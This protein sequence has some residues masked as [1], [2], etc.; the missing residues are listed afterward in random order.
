MTQASQP[1][2]NPDAATAAKMEPEMEITRLGRFLE[3][4]VQRSRLL[5]RIM[6]GIMAALVIANLIYPAGYDR[7][8]WET[9]GGAGAM[10]GL[11]SCFVIVVVSKFLGYKLLY[12]PEDYFD[13]EREASQ[14]IGDPKTRETGHD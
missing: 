3:G 1:T 5:S 8:F 2:H 6:L 14:L 4:M 11:F 7:F 10:Y 9:L 13:N 12:R